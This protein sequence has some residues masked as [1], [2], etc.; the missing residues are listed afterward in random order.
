MSVQVLVAS[1]NQNDHS[2]VEKMRI[3]SDAIVG[4][5]CDRNCVEAFRFGGH[6]IVYLNCNERGVGLNRNNCLLRASADYCIIA[7]DD[8]VFCADYSS[9]VEKA[10]AEKPDADFLVFNIDE[11]KQ[12]GRRTN[13][14]FKRIG[15]FNYMNY[16][17]ARF[18]FRRKAIQGKAVSFN[19][20]FGGGTDHSCGE[21]SLF[22]RDCLAKRMRIYTAPYCIASLSNER[23]S[24]W[25][26]GYD[27]KYFYDKG[28]FLGVAHPFLCH[29]FALYLTIRHKECFGKGSV[30]KKVARRAIRKGIKDSLNYR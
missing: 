24:S 1:M 8:M 9:I 22:I 28:F 17:A 21:D 26:R 25:F 19:L 10:F 30:S 27:E 7:D 5:Q 3:S 23:E 6:K 29:L 14:S 15:L 13:K 11:S 16:G 2:L 20:G 18:V 4:N 12:T